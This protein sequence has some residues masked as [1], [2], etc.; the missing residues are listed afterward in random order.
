LFS[1]R[2]QILFGLNRF[3]SKY[4]MMR[5]VG[6]APYIRGGTGT[7]RAL[8]FIR[9]RVFRLNGRRRTGGRRKVLV[10]LTDGR[11]Q[12]DVKKPANKL[13]K[14]GVDIISVGIG[15]NYLQSELQTMATN[16]QRVFTSAFRSLQRIAVTVK[17]KA[18]K[19]K[20]QTNIQSSQ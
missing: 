8:N 6:R 16:K 5:A 10:V 17:R 7:G 11:S 14:A 1:K 13:K 19:S 2:P 12:D 20:F 3:Y 15:K 4:Q 9:T 18:C